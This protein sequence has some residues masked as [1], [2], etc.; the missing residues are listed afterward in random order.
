[1]ENEK[2]GE[3][4][5]KILS[6]KERENKKKKRLHEK[7]DKIINIMDSMSLENENDENAENLRMRNS[8]TTNKR[9]K[10]KKEGG[11]CNANCSI[12]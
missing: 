6:K 5:E 11:N 2:K 4:G 12:Y 7:E 10:N 8:V 1:M 3:N 9:E